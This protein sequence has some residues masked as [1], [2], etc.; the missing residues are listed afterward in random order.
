MAP[1]RESWHIP[2]LSRNMRG[3]LF[4]E[5]VVGQVTY[6][7]DIPPLMESGTYGDHEREVLRME[8]QQFLQTMAAIEDL[9]GDAPPAIDLRVGKPT[10]PGST[11]KLYIAVV[12]R[13]TSHDNKEAQDYAQLLWSRLLTVFPRS[14]GFS[15]PPEHDQ[16]FLHTV[17]PEL[18]DLQL[19]S[20]WELEKE[21]Y[22]VHWDNKLLSTV[23]T[24]SE[25]LDSMIACWDAIARFPGR[26]LLSVRCKPLPAG[27]SE[28]TRNRAAQHY[29]RMGNATSADPGYTFQ[30]GNIATRFQDTPLV[31]GAR[32]RL[33]NL[34]SSIQLLQLRI[35]IVSW[36][37]DP[38][39]VMAAVKA[40]LTTSLD[41]RQRN[42]KCRWYNC[43]LDRGSE[44]VQQALRELAY[45]CVEPREVEKDETREQYQSGHRPNRAP[46]YDVVSVAEAGAAWRLPLARR[47]GIAGMQFKR[48]PLFSPEAIPL[49]MEQAGKS[50]S[51]I[52]LGVVISRRNDKQ[53]QSL[54]INKLTRHTLILG[55]IGSGKST[56]TQSI[57]YQLWNAKIP[58]MVIDPVSTEYSELWALSSIFRQGSQRLCVFTPGADGDKG[59][60]LSFNPFCP[61]PGISLDAHIMTLKDCFGSAFALPW[62]WKEVV[63][64]AIR[65]VYEDFGWPVRDSDLNRK[66]IRSSDI[67]EGLFPSLIDLVKA[68]ER[69]IARYKFGEFRSNTEAG[70]LGR[71]RDLAV[72]PLG[73]LVNT[74][75]GL[76][77]EALIKRPVVIELRWIRQPDAKSLI[78]LFL[79]TQ[80]RQHYDNLPRSKDIK[81]VLIVEE[82]HRLLSP[83]S[84]NMETDIGSD[85]R[86]ESIQVVVD[87]LAELRKV[88][89]G[90]VLV[91]QLPTRLEAN[92]VK[93][94]GVKILHRLSAK[95]DRE[96]IAQAMNMTPEQTKH[97]TTLSTGQAAFFAEGVVEPILL[98]MAN[99]W[100]EEFDSSHPERFPRPELAEDQEMVELAAEN[101]TLDDWSQTDK[102]DKPWNPCRW[103]LCGC[104]PRMLLL[105]KDWW[106]DVDPGDI[107]VKAWD[108]ICEDNTEELPELAAQL[109]SQVEQFGEAESLDERRCGLVMALESYMRQ[110]TR[111]AANDGTLK[112]VL[113]S[114]YAINELLM[115]IESLAVDEKEKQE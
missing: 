17:L 78:M 90:M 103:C 37:D 93:L 98:Q 54:D 107:I 12:G 75:R 3:I 7:P 31:E 87:M 83:T 41:T 95:D 26:V 51:S 63:G 62:S 76:D 60:L 108:K 52:N 97:I 106:K 111:I 10:G 61:Q 104:Q 56:T 59:T 73:A 89:V 109:W 2:R 102:D 71:L 80:L 53:Q 112:G 105:E 91:E 6:L 115:S 48:D 50:S 35:Q 9:E 21:S 85:S 79:L 25:I 110:A 88:G 20:I 100:D 42:C 23:G 46:D 40:S 113:N 30:A 39:A 8:Q 82:A 101:Q 24:Y 11:P 64:R 68:V 72:G 32:H 29:R 19:A 94:P 66:P 55:E 5:I 16:A 28:D 65:S 14:Y 44:L 49:S 33:N 15:A 99:P 57:V 96:M 45:V 38:L 43:V 22:S 27:E 34:L 58:S 86:T 13:V 84:V 67:Q 36:Q 4:H 92:I 74:R 81:H 1:D 77:V 70:L 18:E 69:E 114:E 47:Y